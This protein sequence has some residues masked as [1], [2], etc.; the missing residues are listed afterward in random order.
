MRSAY[1]VTVSGSLRHHLVAGEAAQL[2]HRHEAVAFRPQRSIR[3]GSSLHGL[4]AVAAGIVQQDDIAA[5]I[6]IGVVHLLL[7]Q[8]HHLI[9]RQ[10]L[11]IQRVDM[12]A[13]R[14]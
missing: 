11:P 13:D 12:R 6:G 1:S 4:G 8:L 2:R 10:L 7:D 9:D 5:Q 14:R 3:M